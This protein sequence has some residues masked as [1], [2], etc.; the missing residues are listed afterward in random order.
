MID[1]E[2]EKKRTLTTE[3]IAM[4]LDLSAQADG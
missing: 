4:I 1:F 2:F 3:Q